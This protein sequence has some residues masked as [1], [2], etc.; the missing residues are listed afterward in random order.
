MCSTF[1][2]ITAALV[3][4][5]LAMGLALGSAVGVWAYLPAQNSPPQPSGELPA[6]GTLCNLTYSAP[7]AS[8]LQSAPYNLAVLGSSR[9]LAQA[10]AAASAALHCALGLYGAAF[11][12]TLLRAARWQ[13]L[14]PGLPREVPPALAALLASACSAATHWAG[15]VLPSLLGLLCLAVGCGAGWGVVRLSPCSGG[16]VGPSAASASFAL[17]VGALALASDCCAHFFPAPE[18]SL[19]DDHATGYLSLP[20]SALERLREAA[21]EDGRQ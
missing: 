3:F 18:R 9:G 17:C 4:D 21:G 16:P 11:A 20:D 12:C 1:T 13:A 8:A 14:L 15:S 7:A 19:M 10:S 2:S 6:S 5:F